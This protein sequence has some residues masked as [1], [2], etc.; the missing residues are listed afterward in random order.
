MLLNIMIDQ[1]CFPG[2]IY[3]GKSPEKVIPCKIFQWL[4]N[5]QINIKF[6]IVRLPV[7][8]SVSE[9]LYENINCSFLNLLHCL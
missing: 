9:V 6:C 5:L 2:L 3:V 8:G 1:E 7:L 4:S